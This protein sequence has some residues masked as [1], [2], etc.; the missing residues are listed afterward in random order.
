MRYCKIQICALLALLMFIT[1]SGCSGLHDYAGETTD[2]VLKIN[3]TGHEINVDEGSWTK[4]YVDASQYEGIRTLRIIAVAV[5]EDENEGVRTILRNDKIEDLSNI[6][7]YNH[8]VRNLPYGV[9]VVFYVIANE[10]SLEMTYTD[11]VINQ[12]LDENKKILFVDAADEIDDRLFPKTGPQ[13]IDNGLPMTGMSQEYIIQHGIEPEVSLYR[14]VLKISLVVENLTDE[15]IKLTSVSFGKFFGDRFYLFREKEL[16]V[17]GDTKYESKTYRVENIATISPKEE[18]DP[19]SL[20]LYPAFSSSSDTS[21]PVYNSPFTLA[22]E[23]NVRTYNPQVFATNTNS[24]IRNTQVNLH[25]SITTIGAD[26]EFN[27]ADWD[28][29]DTIEVPPFE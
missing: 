24:F 21:F 10:E 22:M 28:H 29:Y 7:S 12:K 23:T 27:V 1:S 13:I 14:S 17:P 4:A 25:V 9:K 3:M 8:V 16:D 20:Y 2:V 5:S 6:T 26:V 15:E 18:C 19:L 11:D